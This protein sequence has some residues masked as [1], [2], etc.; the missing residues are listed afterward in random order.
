MVDHEV[1]DQEMIE[2][3]HGA[4]WSILPYTSATQSG[5]IA[6][7]YRLSRPVIAFNVGAISEQVED[8]ETGFLI[9]AGNGE[10]F[11]AAVKKAASMSE[12]ETDRF[13]HNAYVKGYNKYAAAA[14]ADR[15]L[16]VITSL[17]K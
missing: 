6:D 9:E 14:V 7:S 12:E 13:A 10:A 11:A 2:Y 4:D 16:G 3:F 15:F 17:K 8:G 1:S 5:V